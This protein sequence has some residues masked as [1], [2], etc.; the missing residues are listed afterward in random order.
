MGT[1]QNDKMKRTVTNHYQRDLNLE[2]KSKAP[3]PKETII[4]IILLYNHFCMHFISTSVISNLVFIKFLPQ[5][6]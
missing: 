2:Q 4:I 6:L 1:K 3:E 5:S